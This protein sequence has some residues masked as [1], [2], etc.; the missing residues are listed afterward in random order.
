MDRG[1]WEATVHGVAKGRTSNSAAAA[2]LKLTRQLHVNK[3]I[4]PKVHAEQDPP[5]ETVSGSLACHCTGL[6]TFELITGSSKSDKC[7]KAKASSACIK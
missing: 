7:K 1:G 5:S 2:Y 6:S 3:K 4:T